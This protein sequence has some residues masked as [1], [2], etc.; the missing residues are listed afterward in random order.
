MIGVEVGD[1]H[2]VDVIERVAQC[3]EQAAGAGGREPAVDECEA[4]ES[5][6]A[7]DENGAVA[8]GAAGED[9]EFER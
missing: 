5:A 3:A 6:F 9:D 7:A 1:E 8:R 2:I 4:A